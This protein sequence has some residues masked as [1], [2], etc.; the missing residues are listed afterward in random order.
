MYVDRVPN[1]NSPPAIL[2][3]EAW[4]EGGRI[5]KRT[6]ANLSH[7]PAHKVEALRRV[8]RDEPVVSPQEIFRIQ[9]SLPHGHVEAILGTIG[10]LG[11]DG[12]IASKR[13]RS[14]DLVLAMIVERLIHPCSKLATTRLWD[15]T[16]LGEELAVSDADEDELYQ[17]LDWL[18]EHQERIEKK[19]AGRHLSEGSRVLYD[20]SSSYY[21]GRTCPLACF[22]YDRDGKKGL[23]IIV[24]GVLADPAGR[25]V[26]VDAVRT[27]RV[28]PGNTG[29]PTTVPDQV[30]KLRDQFGLSRVVL[31][32]DRGMLTETQIEKLKAYPGLGWISALRS[33]SIRELVDSGCLQ[34]SLFDQ[35]N[36]AEISS[37]DYP[38]ERLIACFNPLLAEERKRQRQ[39]LLE[40]TEKQLKKIARE[41]T[42]RTK[43]PM[44]KAEIALKVGRVIDRFKMAKHLELTIQDGRL[45]WARCEAAIEREA[46]LDGI[47]VIRTSEEREQ[48][49]ADETV[50]QYKSLAQVERA[51]R[52]LKG[53][54]LRVRPIH[55]RTVDH[56]RAHIFLCMLAYYVQWHMR[57]A[58]SPILFQDEELQQDRQTRDAVSPAQSS[59]SVKRKKATHLTPDGLPVH[60]FDTLL[61]ALATRTRNTCTIK[62][63]PSS[64]STFRQ[65]TDPSPLQSRA[66]ELLGL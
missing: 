63:D 50:R 44:G 43:T 22:G 4:R 65:I 21:E 23:P 5:R 25:P 10:K 57:E 60:S 45:Q 47:Y 31:V 28:Y 55:H 35:Q 30:K 6:I 3:R 20:V 29:D 53:I 40:E 14:R 59:A 34:M 54:D 24:Y 66:F 39:A 56:V 13:S 15:S 26:A 36:L 33:R 58:L 12:L 41:V 52:C 17:A 18:L 62:S 2:L 7:W 1:R 16:T 61:L 51:F 42:R 37:P 11:L 9:Q 27:F 38:G 48:L 8:L 64:K 32:G 19:L 49:S 46:Q